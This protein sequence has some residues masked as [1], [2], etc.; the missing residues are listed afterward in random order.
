[1]TALALALLLIGV[2]QAEEPAPPPPGE[3]PVRVPWQP[4]PYLRPVVGYSR[5][6]GEGGAYGGLQL[7]ATGGLALWKAPVLERTRVL[8]AWTTGSLSGIDL[9][10]GS[11]AGV[12]QEWWG[13]SFGPDLFW[14]RCSTAG[15]DLLAPS[16]G[17]DFPLDLHLGPEKV[18]ALGGLVPAV[19]FEPARRADEAL[20]GHEFGWRAG[21]G[22]HFGRVGLNLQY[23]RRTVAGGALSGWGVSLSFQG[24]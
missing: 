23:S 12:E 21:I 4:T 11:F 24:A 6:S 5:F 2:G 3:T 13:L 7:G 9:R 19:L 17:L 10:L 8:V 20:L 16:L 14:N 1:M 18:Y 15:A 22:A